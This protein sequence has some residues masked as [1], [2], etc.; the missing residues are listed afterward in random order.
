MIKVGTSG[1]SFPD[2]KGT[3]YPP[4]IQPRD[5]LSFYEKE[6]GFNVVEINFTYYTL[7]S[8]KSLMAMS[9]KT[10]PD[11]EFVVKSFKGM[12]HDIWD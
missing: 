7:P 1:F 11:F 2:W 5:M 12:T 10:S 6:L 4:N 8:Q 3:V 9:Q